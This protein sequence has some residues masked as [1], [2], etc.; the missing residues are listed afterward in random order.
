MH[1]QSC[2]FSAFTVLFCCPWVLCCLPT[3]Q[4]LK[5][6]QCHALYY[7][8][9]VY[10][11]RISRFFS[12]LVFPSGELVLMEFPQQSSVDSGHGDTNH[13]SMAVP[14]PFLN[15]RGSPSKLEG[16]WQGAELTYE[17]QP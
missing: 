11:C 10:F 1:D 17:E 5:L 16:E 12:C 3:A 14:F 9:S 4:F 6:T 8:H 15:H 7:S 13:L 2:S